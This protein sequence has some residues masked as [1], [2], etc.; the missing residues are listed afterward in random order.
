MPTMNKSTKTSVVVIG[1]SLVGLSTALFLASWKVP[2]I[3]LERHPGS[4]LHPRALGYTTRTIELYRSVGIQSKLPVA[5][6]TG[7]PPRRVS[8]QSLAGKWQDEQHWTPKAPPN[9]ATRGSPG[10]QARGGPPRN[11]LAEN[12]SPVTA[13]AV[14]QDKIEPVLRETARERGADLRLG[15]K[16]VNWSQDDKG[17]SVTAIDANGVET[18]IEGEYLVACDGAHSSVREA[19]GIKRTGV[20]H[21]KILRS[22]LFLCPQLDK[23]LDT[24][25]GQ[26]QI[27][28]REDGFE[29]F[30]T[31][32]GDGRWALMWSPPGKVEVTR[33]E[34]DAETQ[35]EMIR[36]AVGKDIPSGEI[37]LIT[38]GEWQLSGLVAEQFSVSRVFLAGDAAHA[39]PPNRGGYGANTGIADAHNLAWKLASVINNTSRPAL[40]DTYD[41]ER[42][43]VAT[44]RHDQIFVR[45]DYK[46]HVS[47][48][49]WPGKNTPVL[50]DVAMELGQIYASSAGIISGTEVGEE[51]PVAAAKRPDEWN[52]QPGTRAPHVPLQKDGK[53]ISSLDL[54]GHNWVLVSKSGS[55]KSSASEASE[56]TGVSVTFVQVGP[57]ADVEESD[58]GDV[59]R[60]FGVGE[61]GAILVRPDGYVAWRT[62]SNSEDEL[63]TLSEILTRVSFAVKNS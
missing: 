27:E 29:G 2:V 39:L 13:I 26:F 43:S 63:R 34:M 57:G 47:E 6:W 5:Q 30:M 18:V 3:L 23:Y 31:T 19:L 25:F 36:K 38:S 45:D 10:K 44:V 9:S 32:Y 17:I 22:I 11:H 7:G 41:T 28:G 59:G 60:S 35:L 37:E 49:E 1:G 46:R 8:V 12:F 24:G 20:G 58:G 16:V 48:R 14:A 50:D 42:R 21:L 53:P 4:S 54:F 51:R 62:V 61:T 40:L 15:H 56:A 33:E 55:W 52:G